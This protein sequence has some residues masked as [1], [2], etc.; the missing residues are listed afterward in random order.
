MAKRAL[1]PRAFIKAAEGSS[2]G[3]AYL[4]FGHDEYIKAETQRLAVRAHV[5]AEYRKLAVTHLIAGQTDAAQ[6]LQTAQALPMLGSKTAIVVHDTHRLASAHKG[7]LKEGLDTV[8]HPTLLIFLGP[9][10]PDKRTRFYSWFFDRGSAIAC[11]PLTGSQAESFARRRLDGAGKTIT[12]SALARLLSLTG[13]DAG[14]IARESEK[15]E[16]FVGATPEVGLQDVEV[17]T[18]DSS[19]HTPEDLI[20]A[21]LQR[22]PPVALK[23]SRDLLAAK[24]DAAAIISRLSMHFFD[25]KR[26]EVTKEKNPWQ[27]AKALRLPASRAEELC[28]WRAELRKGQL[29]SAIRQLARAEGLVRSGRVEGSY[30]LDQLVLTLA[31]G[32]MVRGKRLIS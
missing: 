1:S 8:V 19:G 23:L 11:E 4:L 5:P 25:L 21:I 12:D 32:N 20:L 17:V 6:I 18:G 29:S 13:S 2:F 31:G 15:L 7:R 28:Q 27:L 14:I 9:A 24:G 3:G 22:N 26:A 30:V 16:L 10:Q